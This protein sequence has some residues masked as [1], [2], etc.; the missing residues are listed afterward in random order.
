[1]W[2]ARR[3]F[4]THGAA[5]L[6]ALVAGCG[7]K[8][9]ADDGSDL[10]AP[11]MPDGEKADGLSPTPSCDE[12]TEDNIEG[13]Y[14]LAGAPEK[15]TLVEAGM[16]GTRLFLSGRVYAHGATCAPLSGAQIDFWQADALGEY[17]AT[18]Y[19]LRGVFVADAQGAFSIPT[20]LPGRYLNGNTY[21]PRHLHV[22]VS[23]PGHPTLTTQLY[24]KGDP[25]NT[26][27]E[28][29][30]PSLIMPLGR[31]GTARTARFDFVI[32]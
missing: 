10:D 5:G 6:A 23:A 28:F 26:V 27:D 30:R 15:T 31:V 12:D 9:I 22:K 11:G 32:A 7:A 13:P 25:Y 18:G 4:L 2:R 16:V 21:R 14:Y 19:R 24:F 3:Q 8:G 17:D 1:V 20:I 29:I